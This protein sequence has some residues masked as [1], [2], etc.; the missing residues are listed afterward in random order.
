MNIAV[1]VMRMGALD[2][3]DLWEILIPPGNLH[4]VQII[5]RIRGQPGLLHWFRD[6]NIIHN[7][8]RQILCKIKQMCQVNVNNL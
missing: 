3:L 2:Y 7:R 6:S 8:G 4:G 5:L 1:S